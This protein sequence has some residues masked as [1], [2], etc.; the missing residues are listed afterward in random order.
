MRRYLRLYWRLM[1][2]QVRSEMQ[3]RISFM[4][5][6]GG[7]LLITGLDFAMMVILLS[8]FSAIGGWTLAEVAFLYGTSAVSFS[9]AELFVGAF[10]DFDRWVV[11]G[12]FDRILIRP[13]PVVFQMLT[14]EFPL[15]RL[16]RLT[17]GAIALAAAFVLLQPQWDT[18]QWLFFPVML[19]GGMVFFMAVF[20][21]AAT[22]SFWSPQ[23]HE[24]ANI[25]TY[26]GQFMTSYP[27]HIYEAW[28]RSVFTFL[29]PMAFINYYPS[30]YL[31]GKP[32]P[33]GMPAWV[34]LLSP[35]VAL[36]VFRVAL[37]AWR[38]GVT[39]YQSTGN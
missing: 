17:Q 29:I 2:A 5:E 31:L 20:I 6:L 11:L 28:M 9:L 39:H 33:P 27:M 25:F 7:N 3:Y 12:E 34:P 8:R 26:G 22:M 1:G 23:T 24:V 13:L 37:A 16:G 35:V 10:E 4:A 18:A 15:R 36:L 19:I 14:G 30:L 21:L 32:Y 38:I